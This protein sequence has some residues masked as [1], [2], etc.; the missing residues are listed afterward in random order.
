MRLSASTTQC[1]TQFNSVCD[2][3]APRLAPPRPTCLDRIHDSARCLEVGR[4]RDDIRAAWEQHLM[5][6]LGRRELGHWRDRHRTEVM[7]M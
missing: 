1:F 2:I 7:G 6:G 3:L 5:D 4:L